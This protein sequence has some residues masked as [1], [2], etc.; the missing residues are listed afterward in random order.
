LPIP[1]FRL[2]SLGNYLASL[3]LVRALARSR[4][5]DVRAAWKDGVLQVVGGPPAMDDLLDAICEIGAKNA[6][7]PYERGWQN[8]Q[9]E[10]T[11]KKSGGPLA[12]WQ[13]SAPEQTLELLN[14]HAV[15]AARISFNPL[16]GS[17][18]NAGK[19]DFSKGWD[20]AV[21]EIAKAQ[22]ESARCELKHLLLG[23]PITWTIE[24]LNAASWFSEA[25]KLYN[26]GQ[27]PYREGAISPWSMALACEG[28][29]FFAGSPSRRLGARARA[30][31]AFPF[32]TR[33]AAPVS[34]GEAGHDLAEVWAPVWERPMTLP[35]IVTLYS[36]GRAEAG[37]RGVLNPSAFAAAI[38]RRG[39]D[40]GIVEFRR[41][42][43][44]RT[45]SA[46]TFEPR[47][48]GVF[49]VQARGQAAR[50]R[51][52]ASVV[53]ERFLA[54]VDQFRGPL[55][56]R[57][58][59]KRWRY[60]GLRGGIE[61]AMLRVAESPSDSEAACALLDSMVA[62]LD[63][64]DRNRSFRERRVA[65]EPLPIDWLPTLFNG[66]V[67]GRE[68][69]LALTL[70]SSFPAGQ[71]FTVYRFG[72]ELRANRFV[73]TPEVPPRWVWRSA[74]PLSQALAEVLYRRTLDWEAARDQPDPVRLAVPARSGDVDRWLFGR[75]DNELLARWISRLALFDWRNASLA[76]RD[77]G[78]VAGGVR[79]ASGQLC[80]FGLL[81]PLF[82]LRPI[83][84]ASGRGSKLLPE[85]SGAR[86]P[87]AARR[88]LGLL[89]IGDVT[90]AVRFAASRYA[91]GGTAL[92]HQDVPWVC[93]DVEA[94][95]ASLLFPVF[96]NERSMLVSRW[97]RPR[98]ELG[99]DN[100]A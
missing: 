75:A 53:I 4:W 66:E 14:A 22:P 60:V 84:T 63:R 82:D 98:R 45:T 16:L 13:A 88:L 17:G 59:G 50:V 34:G 38:M 64:I 35:E 24:K 6:W 7:T 51:N 37:A 71:P 90:A 93:A 81:Q 23:D 9:K 80:L 21:Q 5:P 96:D 46:N 97:L 11:K 36:R 15:P 29:V 92:V 77:L 58:V 73:H 44:A 72:V 85:E 83:I 41:F 65:W 95:I 89:R 55:A 25:N 70:A 31:G 28:L 76:V 40:A 100:E 74:A 3:G 8:A 69:R 30:V 99:E 62:A 48:D 27:R 26:S 78:S 33:A 12:R 57:P 86:T 32:V 2:D 47:F 43:L 10:G 52:A 49:R 79:Q 87:A 1:G 18:G 61:R 19:R 56:D 68:A 42:V 20:K 94:L 39:V 54:L 67:P 91:M